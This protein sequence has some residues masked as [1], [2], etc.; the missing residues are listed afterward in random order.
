M[1][2]RPLTNRFPERRAD[3]PGVPDIHTLD[4][5]IYVRSAPPV[6]VVTGQNPFGASTELWPAPPACSALMSPGVP[7]YV[8]APGGPCGRTINAVAFTIPASGQ[9]DL[10]RNKLRGCDA[11]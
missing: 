11:V 2:F 3:G 10:G 1:P 8:P 9:G 7:F 6:N 5:I 4:W